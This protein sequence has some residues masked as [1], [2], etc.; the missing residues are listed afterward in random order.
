MKCKLLLL[1]DATRILK[2]IESNGKC[3]VVS[4]KGNIHGCLRIYIH[5]HYL[6]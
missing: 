2:L 1:Q 5:M 3:T 6:S 4:K